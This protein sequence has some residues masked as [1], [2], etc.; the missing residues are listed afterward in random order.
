QRAAPGKLHHARGVLILGRS[1]GRRRLTPARALGFAVFAPFVVRLAVR[2]EALLATLVRLLD[3]VGVD[4]RE[5]LL[6]RAL[7][8]LEAA[9]L[10]AA[11]AFAAP[12]LR[13]H[14]RI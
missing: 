12:A 10:L 5:V 11:Q 4:L 1:F 7:Q 13:E 14:R 8:Q 2:G 6:G 9:A 3:A